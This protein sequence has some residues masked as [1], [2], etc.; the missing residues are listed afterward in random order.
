M[1]HRESSPE[2]GPQDVRKY[3]QEFTPEDVEIAILD[4][5]PFARNMVL[6]WLFMV[7]E[8]ED[9]SPKIRYRRNRVTLSGLTLIGIEEYG[10]VH[11]T[12]VDFKGPGILL[13]GL[14][15]IIDLDLHGVVRVEHR[16]VSS[17]AIEDDITEGF[18][19]FLAEK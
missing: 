9:G 1:A 6:P 18:N 16:R 13:R 12:T 2:P 7:D 10:K 14:S 4:P 3:S 15:R 19:Q 8:H 17:E 11:K 5:V